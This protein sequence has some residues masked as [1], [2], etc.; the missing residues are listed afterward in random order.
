MYKSWHDVVREKVHAAT[1]IVVQNK[2]SIDINLRLI[3]N[4]FMNFKKKNYWGL[5]IETFNFFTNVM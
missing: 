1:E 5:G 4:I 3:N 2:V